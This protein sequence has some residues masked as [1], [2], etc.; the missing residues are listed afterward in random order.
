MTMRDQLVAWLLFGGGVG[1]VITV[2]LWVCELVD[3]A[4]GDLS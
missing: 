1:L 2:G 4:R 3:D